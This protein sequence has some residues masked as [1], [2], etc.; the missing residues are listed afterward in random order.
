MID[1]LMSAQL[2]LKASHNHEALFAHEPD[3]L[4]SK[5]SKV[6][7]F[8]YYNDNFNFFFLL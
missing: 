8:I 6:F 5:T 7:F 1:F 4:V 3:P 2:H